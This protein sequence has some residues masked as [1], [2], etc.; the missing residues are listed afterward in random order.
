MKEKNCTVANGRAGLGLHPQR[1]WSMESTINERKIVSEEIIHLEE[2]TRI[3]TAIR[4]RKQGAWT[5]WVR[6]KDI[7]VTWGDFKHIEPPKVSFLIKAV[8]DALP[9]QVNLHVLGLPTSDQCR[10]CGITASLKHILTECEYSLRSYIWRHILKIFAEPAI[11]CCETA[12]KALNNN[13]NR[14]I[15]FVKEKTFRNFHVKISADHHWSMATCTELEHHFVF[16][17]EITL[18]T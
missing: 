16:P 11:I 3:P 5:K 15:H 2:V 7:T 13:T 4:Q 9:T 10:A 17:T 14:G 18:T 8:Y 1:W 12:N 6:A